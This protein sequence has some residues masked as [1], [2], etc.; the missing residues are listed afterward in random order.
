MLFLKDKLFMNRASRKHVFKDTFK[1]QNK[2]R[3]IVGKPDIVTLH[4]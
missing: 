2:K 4:E 1:K 3:G